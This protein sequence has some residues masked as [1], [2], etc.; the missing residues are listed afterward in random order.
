MLMDTNSSVSTYDFIVISFTSLKIL[1]KIVNLNLFLERHH[2]GASVDLTWYSCKGVSAHFIFW[3]ILHI[4]FSL[5]INTNWI[6]VYEKYFLIRSNQS[7]SSY[8]EIILHQN[9]TSARHSTLQRKIKM[10]MKMVHQKADPKKTLTKNQTKENTLCSIKMLQKQTCEGWA[11]CI[12]IWF[13]KILGFILWI[14]VITRGAKVAKGVVKS[15]L[16]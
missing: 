8:S 7:Q 13:F 11:C 1:E 12:L 15:F 6:L 9:I 2:C 10:S 5:W 16:F 4:L 3:S 14:A